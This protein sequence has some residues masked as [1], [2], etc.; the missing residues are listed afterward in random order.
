MK[1]TICLTFIILTFIFSSCIDKKIYSSSKEYSGVIVFEYKYLED[2]ERFWY[3]TTYF[4]DWESKKHFS[5]TER[6][7]F[8]GDSCRSVLKRI[9]R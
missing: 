9:S 4:I 6:V 2:Y 1:T 5:P 3:N 8:Y 7:P